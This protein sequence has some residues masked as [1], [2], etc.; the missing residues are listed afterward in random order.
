[1]AKNKTQI[2]TPG[3]GD[4]QIKQLLEPLD[5]V[6]N[7]AKTIEEA[8]AQNQ[9]IIDDPQSA[10][11][12]KNLAQLQINELS[13]TNTVIHNA[14]T[15][16]DSLIATLK[17]QTQERAARTRKTDLSAITIN[18]TSASTLQG[19]NIKLTEA[20]YVIAEPERGK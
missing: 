6:S 13:E 20:G 1:M 7:H 3:G 9:A 18:K 11:D 14:M 10:E 17:N 2:E 8:I 4:D 15:E 19:D 16:I 12:A 5:N